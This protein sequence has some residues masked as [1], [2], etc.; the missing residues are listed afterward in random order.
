MSV[1]TLIVIEILLIRTLLSVPLVAI[2]WN[3]MDR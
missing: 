1:E 2:V 3:E